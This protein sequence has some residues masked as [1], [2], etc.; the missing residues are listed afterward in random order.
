MRKSQAEMLL[1]LGRAAEYRDGETGAHIARMSRYCAAIGRQL[2]LPEEECELLMNAS[3]MHDIGKIGVPDAVLLKAG[4]LDAEEWRKM[5]AHVEI[6][7][8]LLSG[9]TSKLVKAAEIIARTHHEKWDGT[10]Y[11]NQLC[12]KEIPLYGRIAAIAD[13]FDALTSE[14][15]YKPA[16]TPDEAVEEIRAQA[17]RH[18]DPAIVEVFVLALPNILEIM[19]KCQ[20][21]DEAFAAAA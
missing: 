9:G 21:D 15:P 2:G 10:G 12:G 17:G 1:R 8:E 20:S 11:P 3:T 13:V 16:W 6:G 4:G 18:F 5:K 14:R 19:R 7:S